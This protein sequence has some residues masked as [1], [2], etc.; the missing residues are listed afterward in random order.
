MVPGVLC[1]LRSTTDNIGP[2]KNLG[3][4][5]KIRLNRLEHFLQTQISEAKEVAIDT[6]CGI[7]YECMKLRA[8]LIE[9]DKVGILFGILIDL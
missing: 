5:M 3:Y 9:F 4:L 6:T 8:V 2:T 1:K 7:N